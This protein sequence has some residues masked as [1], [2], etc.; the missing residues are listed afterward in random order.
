MPY[1]TGQVLTQA[2]IAALFT[3]G[4]YTPTLGNMVIGTG[5]TPTNSAKFTFV[6][7]PAGGVLTVEG[8]IKFGTTG[9]T[10]PAASAET[11]S[12][13]SGYAMIDATDVLNE[14]PST[15]TF[16]DVSAV[17]PF[18]GILRPN[19][20]TTVRLIHLAVSGSS[21]IPAD[22]TATVPFTWAINDEIYY[23]FSARCTGP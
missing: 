8:K 7:F 22:V 16:N 2:D 3:S 5:G 14:L 17:L 15:V 4:T 18:K 19:S 23:R 12:L 6:G 11:I 9:T 13:P 21:I 1:L 10:L 20:T